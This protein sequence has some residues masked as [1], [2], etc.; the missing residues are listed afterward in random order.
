MYTP[1]VRNRQ[2]EMLAFQGLA[3]EVREH[4]IPLFDVAA[5]TKS[6][7]QAKA[8]KYVTNNIARTQKAANGHRAVFID[9]SELD[10]NFRLPGGTHPL[11]EAAM[12][13]TTGGARPIPVTGLHRDQ[14]HHD[15]TMEIIRKTGSEVCMRLDATDVSTASMSYRAIRNFLSERKLATNQ[16][17]VLLDL[18]G[19]YGAEVQVVAAPVLRLLNLLRADS[20]AGLIIGGYGVPEQLSTAVPPN[21]QAYLP[22]VEQDVY[23]SIYTQI[24]G[25]P[26]WFADYT[27]LPPSTIELDWRLISRVM[28]PKAL[29]ALD[30]AWLVVRGSAFSSHPDGYGQY[31]AIADE[32]VALDEFSGT[33]FSPGDQYIADRANRTCTPGSPATWI[34]AC[35]S[36][37]LSLTARYHAL[38]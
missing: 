31:Y 7:D 12:F 37:H 26:L 25:L 16:I 13:V 24:S 11:V 1:I 30:D 36:H 28:A 35:V 23:F 6:A 4:M 10:P 8:E 38:I 3:P 27:M 32:I 34:R 33:G 19:L 5:P 22:R 14:A 15:A 9:S 29:Y 20:W 21:T 18:Q 2:S 17:F